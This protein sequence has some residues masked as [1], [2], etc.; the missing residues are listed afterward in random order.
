MNKNETTFIRSNPF[1][2]D[3]RRSANRIFVGEQFQKRDPRISFVNKVQANLSFVLSL[4][5]SQ[6]HAL[7]SKGAVLQS[8]RRRFAVLERKTLSKE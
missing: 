6:R 2:H 8:V 1:S 5:Q 3:E 4:Q 7:D